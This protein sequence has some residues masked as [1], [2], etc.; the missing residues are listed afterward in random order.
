MS[1][2]LNVSPETWLSNMKYAKNT[3]CESAVF[4]MASTYVLL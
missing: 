3:F 2:M 4:I 1:V